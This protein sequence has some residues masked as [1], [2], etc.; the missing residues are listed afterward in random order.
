MRKMTVDASRE[1]ILKT[2]NYVCVCVCHMINAGE[3][4]MTGMRMFTDEN[5]LIPLNVLLR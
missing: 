2:I 1:I 4:L 3:L 5:K